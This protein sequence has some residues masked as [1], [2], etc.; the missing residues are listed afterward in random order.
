VT[1]SEQTPQSSSPGI[2][3]T[4]LANEYVFI[5]ISGCGDGVCRIWLER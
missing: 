2:S 4:N 5:I 3:D 1:T